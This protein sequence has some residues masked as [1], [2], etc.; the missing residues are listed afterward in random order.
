MP[1]GLLAERLV[2]EGVRIVQSKT[3]GKL[4][5]QANLLWPLLL[6]WRL[7]GANLELG[8][9][10]VR[11]KP[12]VVQCNTLYAII[13]TLL[14]ARILKV[15]VVWHIHDFASERWLHAFMVRWFSKGVGHLIAVSEAVRQDLIS[16]GV[17]A[18]HVSTIYNSAFTLQDDP[19]PNPVTQ[20]IRE[21]SKG[22]SRLVGMMGTIEERK[23]ILLALEA[24]SLAR[25]QSRRKIGLVIAGEPREPLQLQYKAALLQFIS[26][27]QLHRDVLFLGH[28]HQIKSFLGCIDAF[29]HVPKD[30]DPLPTVI[31]EAITAETPVIV[32]DKGGNSELVQNGRW[33]HVIPANDSQALAEALLKPLPDILAGKEKRAFSE[34]FSHERKEKAHLE[35]YQWLLGN[36]ANYE[37]RVSA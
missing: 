36:Q 14:P 21:F 4:N 9:C 22:H 3:L 18:E 30:P 16:T 37:N 7:I 24:L 15:P 20:G 25:K 27:H 23:G 32:S 26:D 5:K 35:L 6:L 8:R 28:I 11:L 13:Y 34:F 29:I 33:G 12:Q 31:L 2:N 17:P 19:A 1:P 10:L